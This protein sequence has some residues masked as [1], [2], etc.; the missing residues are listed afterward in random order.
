M[1]DSMAHRGPD[2]SDV[3]ELEDGRLALG[4]RRLS[5]IDLSPLGHQPMATD[6]RR[7]WI[8]FNGEIYN[9]RELRAELVPHGFHFRSDS[10][11]EV[12][13]A[14]YRHWGLGAVSRFHGMFAFA[15]WDTEQR[16]LHLCRDRFGV[17]PLYYTCRDGRFAFA[18]E[19][20]AL[21]VEGH[22]ERRIDPQ[23]AA[24]Y[25]RYGYI[26]SPRSIFDDIRSVDPGTVLSIDMRLG[27][28]SLRYWSLAEQHD[29]AETE[30]LRSAL[31]AAPDEE[32][33]DRV[34]A[35]L[36]TAFRYRMVADVPVGLFLSGG[37]DS[38]LV[39]TLLARRAGVSLRT[40]T[41]GYGDSE[42]DETHYARVVAERLGAQHT[43]F[44]VSHDEALKLVGRITEVADEPIGDSSLIPTLLVSQ[45]ARRHVTVALSADGADELFGGYSR[46]RA[47]ASHAYRGQ[48]IAGLPYR[49]AARALAALPAGAVAAMYR[50]SRFRRSGYAAIEDKLRKFSRMVRARDLFGAYDA[51]SSEWSEADCRRLLRVGPDLS[52]RHAAFDALDARHGVMDRLMHFDAVTYLPGDLLTK[53]DRASMAVSLEAREPFLDQGVAR[54]AAALPPE[55]KVRGGRNKYVLQR[56]LER[57]HGV[58]F[59]DRPKQGFSVPLA[60]W[61]HGPLREELQDELSPSRVR[62]V[63][64][65]DSKEVTRIV[66]RFYGGQPDVSAAGIWFIFQFQRWAGRWLKPGSRQPPAESAI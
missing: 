40:F 22:T 41:I 36:T 14:A 44:L 26:G 4:H 8:V 15:L 57:Y 35:A 52:A 20:R 12:I 34:E 54:V 66:H 11:T 62:S 60:K 25:L 24:E 18:S 33:L 29:L 5:I 46:Y 50:L 16:T 27:A 55:W 3:T 1:C 51:A 23:A 6:D 32:L 10:D 56:L 38:S 43:E 47:C 45:L 37:I 30:E 58:G 42:F 13:L 19:M 31:H 21:N 17:K 59:F 2:D 48:G 63:D 64:V 28:T 39:A 9:Y 61:L 65:F 49:A 7:L 53:V